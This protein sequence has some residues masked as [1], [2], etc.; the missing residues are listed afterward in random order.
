VLGESLGAN[1]PRHV[2]LVQGSHIVIRSRWAD[3][4]A[5]FFQ[6]A[7]G[8][9]IFAIPYEDDFTLIGTTDREF[10]G[11]PGAARADAEE[12]RYL[13]AA[14]SEYL[15]EPVAPEDVVWAFSG[16]RPLFDDGA[17]KAQEATRDYVLRSE[18]KPALINI[19]GGKLT[20][21]RRLAEAVLVQVEAALGSRAGS[22]TGSAPLP[23]GDFPVEGVEDL[24]ARLRAGRPWLDEA[25]ARRLA[26]HYGTA[27]ER[28][29]GEARDV[30][31]LG[32]AFGAGLTEAEVA[33][34]VEHEWAETG[35]DI[36]WR[37]T[38]LGLRVGE[39][40]AAELD[41]FVRRAV[42]ARQP[43]AAE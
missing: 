40:A 23:G 2:R 31:G 25:L 22:W 42:A 1:G 26:R 39:E 17:S 41:A 12:V 8:R 18:G 20:T 21:Y 32:R 16:V 43:V 3:G 11:D 28:I 14:A 29:L 19:F 7:D 9:V 6:A 4:R 34:L 36:L 5:F 30:G 38:K 35:E 24:V 27:A 13:C 33:Y 10:H 15:A 37:R